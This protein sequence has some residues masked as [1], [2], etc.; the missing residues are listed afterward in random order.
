MI[1]RIVKMKFKH[2]H[3][4]EFQKLFVELYPVISTFEGCNHLSLLQ[5]V[6]DPGS[7]MTYSIWKNEESLNRYRFSEFFKQTR[8]RTKVLFDDRPMAISLH[9]LY[10]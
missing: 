7:M 9:K 8:S 10:P 6:A 1:V 2:E 4:E 5:D 3:I